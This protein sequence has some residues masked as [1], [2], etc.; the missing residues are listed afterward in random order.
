MNKLRYAHDFVNMSKDKHRAILAVLLKEFYA[1]KENPKIQ[2][3][4]PADSSKQSYKESQGILEE[5]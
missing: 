3:K 5:G 4:T 2:S 1:K